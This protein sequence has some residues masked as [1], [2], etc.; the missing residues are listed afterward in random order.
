ML[1][2]CN[3][4]EGVDELALANISQEKESSN[5]AGRPDVAVAPPDG[6]LMVLV[7]FV[8]HIYFQCINSYYLFFFISTA[9]SLLPFLFYATVTSN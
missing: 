6:Q 9:L 8:C 5:H 2:V 3:I 1:L 4:I 7:W